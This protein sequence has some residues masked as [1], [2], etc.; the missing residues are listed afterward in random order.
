MKRQGDN[1]EEP[2]KKKRPQRKL[3]AK[4]LNFKAQKYFL[5]AYDEQ[6][7]PFPNS[8]IK[9]VTLVSDF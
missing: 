1:L 6:G 7:V 5:N 3:N 4:T 8:F 2:P 9:K